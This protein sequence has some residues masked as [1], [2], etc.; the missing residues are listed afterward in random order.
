MSDSI[1]HNPVTLLRG[2]GD[3]LKLRL[4]EIGIHSL[5]DLLFHFPLRYQDRTRITPIG[6]AP[7]QRDVVIKGD[8]IAAAVTMGVTM[9]F[10]RT[11]DLTSFSL[12]DSASFF[13]SGVLAKIAVA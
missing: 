13:C 11:P 5:E 1:L 6:A 4:A 7:D 8:V 3:K 10:F 12:D 2:V 9:G